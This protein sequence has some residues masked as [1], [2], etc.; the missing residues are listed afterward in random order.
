MPYGKFL[1]RE[2]RHWNGC[3]VLS[4]PRES[5]FFWSVFN[6]S[7]TYENEYMLYVSDLSL[8]VSVSMSSMCYSWARQDAHTVSA[9]LSLAQLLNVLFTEP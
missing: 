9:I 1:K 6:F 7:L 2:L 4:S 8:S 5:L 3:S